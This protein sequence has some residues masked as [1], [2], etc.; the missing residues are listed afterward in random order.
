MILEDGREIRVG[1][2][3]E[4][5]DA[6]RC[7]RVMRPASAPS[8]ASELRFADG[9]LR[10]G[11]AIDWDIRDLF[12][13]L[14]DRVVLVVGGTRGIG[15]AL[16]E[17]CRVRGATVI[18]CGRA[19]CD[20]TDAHAVE[21]FLVR[22]PRI[23]V[24]VQCAALPGGE[25]AAVLA[26]NVTGAFHVASSLTK[27]GA[28]FRFVAV[29]SGVTDTPVAGAAAY[30]TSKH[31]VEGLVR[32]LAREDSPGTFTAVQLGACPKPELALPAL[33]AAIVAPAGDI[34]GRVLSGAPEPSRVD[35]R[36]ANAF[37]SALGPSPR[38]IEAM[39]RVR[40]D[41]HRYP[42]AEATEL[43]AAIAARND[44]AFERVVVGAGASDLLERCLRV[45][46]RR[47]ESVVA[48]TPTW[49]LFPELCR[50]VGLVPRR[51]PYAI[52]RAARTIDHALDAIVEQIDRATHLVY[53]VSPSNPYG[54]AIDREPFARLLA[55]LPDHV[56]VIVDEA[57][58]DYVERPDALRAIDFARK[59]ERVVVLRSFSKLHGL[60]A[61]R[62]GYAIASPM[63]ATKLA[64]AGLPFAVSGIAQSAAVAALADDEHIARVRTAS[65]SD[66]KRDNPRAFASDAPFFFIDDG[67]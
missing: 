16:A 11:R 29:S 53:L 14:S 18:S 27:R 4:V 24:V 31:A 47:G 48:N 41:V 66:P 28:P 35:T 61:L 9:F 49:P 67:E 65:R 6:G 3:I 63:L 30:V 36:D 15:R 40:D 19:D 57:Y 51:V 52:D 45:L 39:A 20:V 8:R 43:R 2:R 26:T 64:N 17:A 21:T 33:L 32:A 42:E 7:L 54:V 22:H 46:G 25:F 1:A 56:T 12:V 10:D 34:H 59:D 23:D 60:A 13:S 37:A 44:V 62:V 5:W 38:A 55:K 58:A 50:R